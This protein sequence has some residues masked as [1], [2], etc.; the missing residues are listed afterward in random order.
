[1][2]P[3]L[4]SVPCTSTSPSFFCGPNGPVIG[5]GMKHS[6]CVAGLP[7][8]AVPKSIALDRVT[9]ERSI[10]APRPAEKWSPSSTEAARVRSMIFTSEFSAW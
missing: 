10:T 8:S 9:S 5:L 2:K 1:M 6:A 7:H 3:R 4:V